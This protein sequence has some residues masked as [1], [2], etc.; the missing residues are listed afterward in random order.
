MK[1]VRNR[2]S[3]KL[4]FGKLLYLKLLELTCQEKE[5]VQITFKNILGAV[6]YFLPLQVC[7]NNLT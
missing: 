3:F 2:F 5:F 7:Q 1:K 4:N 6:S